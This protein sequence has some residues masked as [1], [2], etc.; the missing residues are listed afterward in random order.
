MVNTMNVLK[1][2]VVA[3]A[4]LTC[5]AVM[6]EGGSERAMQA[7]EKMR[8]AQQLRFDDL[9]SNEATRLVNASKNPDT[10]LP[11]KSEG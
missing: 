1:S 5:T 8:V 2:M 7:A 11:R 10:D 9:R 4:A 6:A 3:F